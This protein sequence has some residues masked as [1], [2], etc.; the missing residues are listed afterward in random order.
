MFMY[1]RIFQNIKVFFYSGGLW[2]NVLSYIIFSVHF[3][4][5]AMDQHK[6]RTLSPPTSGNTFWV[7]EA[8]KG[9]FH[10]NIHIIIFLQ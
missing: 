10:G 9:I 6:P 3:R 4:V 8:E 7:I 5:R 2:I 1:N